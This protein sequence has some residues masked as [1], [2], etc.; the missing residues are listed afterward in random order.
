MISKV[1]E[2]E[3]S[4][5][6]A[7]E[8]SGSAPKRVPGP[9]RTGRDPNNNNNNNLYAYARDAHGTCPRPMHP[10]TNDSDVHTKT[11]I[12]TGRAHRG[13]TWEPLTAGQTVQSDQ[14]KSTVMGQ[15][16]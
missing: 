16:Q 10:P 12:Q 5:V 8:S 9:S 6:R 11:Y 2:V 4:G 13:S 14:I 3:A 1:V 15:A 7:L